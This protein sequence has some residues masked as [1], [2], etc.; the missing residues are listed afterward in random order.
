MDN[1]EAEPPRIERVAARIENRRLR[2]EGN[3]RRARQQRTA[4]RDPGELAV[5]H[6][7]DCRPIPALKRPRQR[8][9]GV[10][11]GE[12]LVCGAA[13]RSRRGGRRIG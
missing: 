4:L 8:L 3:N 5:K 11:D 12:L 1:S 6:V 10:A 7:S 9:V 13:D 2:H